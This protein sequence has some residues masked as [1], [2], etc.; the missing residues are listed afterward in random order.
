M[1][2]TFLLLRQKH[3]L[4]LQGGLQAFHRIVGGGIVNQIDAEILKVLL[5]QTLQTAHRVRPAVIVGYDADLH[6]KTPVKNKPTTEREFCCYRSDKNTKLVIRF[7]IHQIVISRNPFSPSY[8]YSYVELQYMLN[9]RA[10][11][12]K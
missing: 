6:N 3:V 4:R 12:S 8:K 5:P 7:I 9:R 11:K 2:V 10:S 1:R